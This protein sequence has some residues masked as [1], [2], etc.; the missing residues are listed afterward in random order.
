M[1]AN[2]VVQIPPAES[3]DRLQAILDA[4]R[5]GF[6]RAGPPSLA[7]RRAGLA[8][9]AGAV[10][11]SIEPLAAA[12]S[13]DF[14]NRSRHETVLAEIFPVLAGI[15][16]TSGHLARWMRPKRVQ[17]SLEL[18]P[19]G[20]RILYQPVGVVGIISP[21]NYPFQLAIMPL[22]AALAAGNR[23]MLKPS[24]LTPRTSDFIAEF[25][26]KLF[27]PDQVA[28]IVGGPDLGQAF[29]RLAFDHLFYTGSTA[30]GR[31]VMRA[32]A[33]NLT[34]V[35][36]ELGGKSPCIVGEDAALPA[37][38]ESIVYG[39]LLNAGQTCIAPDYVLVPEQRRDEFID[40]VG[41]TVK[42]FYPTLAANPDY[43]SIVNERHYRRIAAYVEEARAKG[44][45]VIEL[46][47]AHEGSSPAA[48]KLAP[49]LVI[50][51]AEDLAVMREEIFG[52]VLPVK[53]YRG[54]DEAIDYV[55]RH[56][57]PLALYYFG[58]DRG[59]RDEVLR[60]TVSGG[61]SINETLFHIVV[62]D[63]PFGGVGASG[64]GAYHGEFGF[65]TFSHRKGV[66][67]QS[68]LNG[69]RFLRPPFGKIT[70]MMIKF[71]LRR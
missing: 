6:L 63:L 31:L 65:Q 45:R 29:S 49:T 22:M 48:R 28:T 44:A 50:D 15:R 10:K 43:T 38:V 60:R 8:K 46:D 41:A 54:L 30:V 47:P 13:A 51:P 32:A 61:A 53:T 56:P 19:A 69:A 4:Q 39:K 34:P 40:L 68:R 9:L 70:D 62:E 37:A 33:E 16:H 12:I 1:N 26:G 64:I 17:V 57:R 20:A 55:N 42:R 67:L 5:A 52:P 59:R 66:F 58:A 21:W 71:L 18:M 25:L 7:E 23:V 27:P 24:E 36:L 2:T 35:T 3:T 11:Q 14:G